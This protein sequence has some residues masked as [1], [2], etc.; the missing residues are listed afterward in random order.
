[1]STDSIARAEREA[2]RLL[3]RMGITKPAVDVEAI[4]K[5]LNIDVAY[6]RFKDDL[7]GVL[8]KAGE[9]SA[10]GI[11]SKHSPVR[12][13]FSIAHELAHFW[14]GHPGDMFVDESKGRASIVFRDGRSADGT[15]LHEME[16][17]RFAASLLMPAV[18]LF[19]SLTKCLSDGLLEIDREIIPRLSNEYCVS[20]QAMKIRLSSLGLN[21]LI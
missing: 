12:Q 17:N 11:N 2:Q 4:A 9:R 6:Q 10:I 18:F 16:A 21:T 20:Q 7:S 15:N 5:K 3:S 1:M 13:R 19:E 14:L 8:V